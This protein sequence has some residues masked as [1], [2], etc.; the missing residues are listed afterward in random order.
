M[1]PVVLR[2]DGLLWHLMT[3]YGGLHGWAALREGTDTCEIAAAVIGGLLKILFITVIGGLLLGL[4]VGDFITW[5]FVM[6]QF[7]TFIEPN[8]GAWAMLVIAATGVSIG[9]LVAG[10]MAV[11]SAVDRLHTLPRGAVGEIY[12]SWREKA[13]RPVVVKND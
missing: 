10:I 9:V 13:C 2:G 3:T 1:K 12:Q 4:T 11:P 6:A 8:D 7:G 5:L